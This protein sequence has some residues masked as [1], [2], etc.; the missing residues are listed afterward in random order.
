MAAVKID[1]RFKPRVERVWRKDRRP[2]VCARGS[3]GGRMDFG[4]GTGLGSCNG[5]DCGAG[6]KAARPWEVKIASESG[7]NSENG[8]GG[9]V[10]ISPDAS[11]RR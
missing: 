9:G 6:A 7:L 4:T 5:A 3:G 2:V 10:R 1:G 8:A 11:D